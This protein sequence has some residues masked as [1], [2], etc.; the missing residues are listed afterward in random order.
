VVEI[1]S[2]Y[3]EVSSTDAWIGRMSRKIG[4]VG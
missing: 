2:F 4:A 1:A 3:S